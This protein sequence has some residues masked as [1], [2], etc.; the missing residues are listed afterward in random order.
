MAGK[1]SPSALGQEIFQQ[2]ET[3]SASTELGRD[4]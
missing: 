1:C 2:E 3:S 4:F